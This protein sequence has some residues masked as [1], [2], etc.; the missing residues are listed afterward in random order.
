MKNST[1][2]NVHHNSSKKEAIKIQKNNTE[3]KNF[4]KKS[5]ENKTAQKKPNNNINS[6]IVQ[7]RVK[8]P[9][10]NKKIKFINI[11]KEK[12][13]EI[14]IKEQY[15][16]CKKELKTLNDEKE[17]IKEL[18][19]KLKSQYDKDN[20]NLMSNNKNKKTFDANEKHEHRIKNPILIKMIENNLKKAF[21]SLL[22][23]NKK[24]HLTS[25]SNKNFNKVKPVIKNINNRHKINIKSF[26]SDKYKNDF[27]AYTKD[28]K[29]KYTSPYK[30]IYSAR[31]KT[32][33]ILFDLNNDKENSNKKKN[34]FISPKKDFKLIKK[35]KENNIDKRNKNIKQT[36]KM[37]K[38]GIISKAG[39]EDNNKKKKINQDSFF[40]QDIKDGFKFIGICDGHGQNGKQ[41]SEFIK[42]NMPKELENELNILISNE[43][44]KSL[45]EEKKDKNIIGKFNIILDDY[46]KINELLK[47]V[48]ISTNSKLFSKNPKLNLKTSGSTCI[49]LLY[50]KYSHKKIFIANAGDNRAIIIKSKD[51]KSPWSYEQLNREHTA[52]EKDEAERII[53]SGGEL[54]KIENEKGGVEGPLRIFKKNEDTPGVSMSRS[55]GDSD[56]KNLGVIPEPE[57]KEYL[58]KKGDKAV[59][60]ASNGLWKNVNNEEVMNVVKK[61][62]NKKDGNIIVN[63]LYKLSV[64]KWKK[65]HCNMEDITIICVLLN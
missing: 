53:K 26:S 12:E 45:N 17:K 24:V 31:D 30:T 63:E 8:T 4:K 33:K 35:I 2:M 25:Y 64:E 56:A 55:L 32:S 37:N 10:V 39:M 29:T 40:I 57:V 58:I 5:Q 54:K 15:S 14:G 65:E 21:N 6:N 20:N 13:K 28:F 7:K 49:T 42:N 9:K 16:L 41:V 23:D 34:N 1:K 52:S 36:D 46:E 3:K 43:I 44:K 19:N 11:N 48:F 47:N 50:Q 62:W 61:L 51:E 27:Q 38:I 59:I 22:I 60:I 18:K